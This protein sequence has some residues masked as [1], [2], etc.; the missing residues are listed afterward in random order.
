MSEEELAA[1]KAMYADGMRIDDVARPA[2]EVVQST[3]PNEIQE[4]RKEFSDIRLTVTALAAQVRQLQD[5]LGINPP[6]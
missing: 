5:Q 3:N 1:L 2:H 6:S 4:L